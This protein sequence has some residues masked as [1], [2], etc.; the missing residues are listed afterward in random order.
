MKIFA[1]LVVA[2]PICL[3]ITPPIV[4]ARSAPLSVYASRQ[5]AT[6]KKTS[7]KVHQA[8]GEILSVS[9]ASLVLLH[10]RG[11]TRQRMDFVLTGNTR[12]T[13]ALVK[14]ERVVVFYRETLGRRIATRIRSATRTR[15]A[16]QSKPAS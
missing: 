1:A 11:R 2:L 6:G 7:A 13:V 15:R 14:G 16:R 9:P 5:T 12:K 10:A 8:T 3:G 4:L